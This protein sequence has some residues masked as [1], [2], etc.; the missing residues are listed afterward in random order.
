MSK[1]E[2]LKMALA[3]GYEAMKS[4]E[5]QPKRSEVYDWLT[6]TVLSQSGI[7]LTPPPIDPKAEKAEIA[8]KN[9]TADDTFDKRADFSPL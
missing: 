1:E 9:A 2:Q 3:N 4:E 7:Y 5:K 8:S 6:K